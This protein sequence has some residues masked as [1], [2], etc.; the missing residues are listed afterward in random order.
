MNITS[1]ASES[2]TGVARSVSAFRIAVVTAALVAGLSACASTQSSA[3]VKTGEPHWLEPSPALRQRIEDQAKRLPWTHGVERID[4]IRW[5]A[6]VGEPAYPTL[7][8]MVIDPRKDVAGSALAA[9]GATRDSRL[10]DELHKLPWP[11]SQESNDLALERARTLLR[12]GDWQML[13]M[14][15][16]G[17]RSEDLMTRALCNQALFEATHEKFDFDP[18]GDAEVR[19]ASVQRWEAWWKARSQDPLLQDTQ[20]PARTNEVSH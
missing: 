4:L 15:I 1:I 11:D 13:P 10:V 7:L 17:L 9:L 3:D 8:A 20:A 5:F 6:G 19:E 2:S 16:D 18:K 14:L 12:L